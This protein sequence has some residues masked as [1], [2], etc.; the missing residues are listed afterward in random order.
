MVFHSRLFG[1]FLFDTGRELHDIE[2]AEGSG[3]NGDG[4]V[5]LAVTSSGKGAD[6]VGDEAKRDAVAD[7]SGADHHDDGH[8]ARS[9]GDPVVPIE[10]FEVHEHADTDVDKS[11]VRNGTRENTEDRISKDGKGEEQAGEESGKTRASTS[12]NA[13]SGFDEG[14]DGRGAE[15]GTKNGAASVNDHRVAVGD[16]DVA[17]FVDHAS[18]NFNADQG[19]GGVEEVDEEKGEDKGIGLRIGEDI[20]AVEASTNEGA[21]VAPVALARKQEFSADSVDARFSKRGFDDAENQHNDDDGETRD[22]GAG[23]VVFGESGKGENKDDADQSDEGGS[24]FEVAHGK[25]VRRNGD[26]ARGFHAKVGDEESNARGDGDFDVLRNGADNHAAE[27]GNGDNKEENAIDEDEAHH[28]GIVEA[29]AASKIASNHRVDAHARSKS[30][31][32]FANQAHRDGGDTSGK[33]G[34]NEDTSVSGSGGEIDIAIH[35]DFACVS[36]FGNKSGEPVGKN[37]RVDVED[38]EHR[39]EGDQATHEFAND[40]GSSFA[41]MEIPVDERAELGLRRPF[42]L[43]SWLLISGPKRWIFFCFFHLF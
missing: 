39:E 9:D 28:L 19:A 24:V 32:E 2:C 12:G 27:R 18:T 5:F 11:D 22:P 20:E 42:A 21:K 31:R 40:R 14:S 6:R 43:G 13:G 29:H 33:S 38:V 7:R 26:D 37:S 10:F 4:D 1:S 3:Q 30:D 35:P 23:F 25:A 16:G 34:G 8:E 15:D 41:D 36:A 17:V